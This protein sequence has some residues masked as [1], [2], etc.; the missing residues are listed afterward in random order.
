MDNIDLM[1]L[2]VCFEDAQK[3]SHTIDAEY[4]VEK[5]TRMSLGECFDIENRI[6]LLWE[7][8]YLS[9][10]NGQYYLTDKSLQLIKKADQRPN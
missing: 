1:I 8:N 5:M 10:S 2:N 7:N 4:L 3:G 9:S 6:G